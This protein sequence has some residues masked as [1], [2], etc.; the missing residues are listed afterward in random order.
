[1]IGSFNKLMGGVAL[2]LL[3]TLLTLEAQQGQGTT[4]PPAQ[5]TFDPPRI[6]AILRPNEAPATA[7]TDVNDYFINR[8]Q[9]VN[10]KRG[11]KLN[12]YR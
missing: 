5:S 9:E 11:D 12:V 6:L 4:E 10:I 7:G 1:M 2:T 8:G 3:C